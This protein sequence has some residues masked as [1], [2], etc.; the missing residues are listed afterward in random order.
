MKVIVDKQRHDFLIITEVSNYGAIFLRN[1]FIYNIFF[2]ERSTKDH[3]RN[4]MIKNLYVDE[5]VHS[6]DCQFIN[7]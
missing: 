2:I 7:Q 4:L 1:S 5:L 3:I 6:F